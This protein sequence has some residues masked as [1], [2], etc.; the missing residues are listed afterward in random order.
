MR[1]LSPVWSQWGR[2]LHIAVF[3]L[4]DPDMVFLIQKGNVI[5]ANVCE[6]L[7]LLP[8][9]GDSPQTAR[10]QIHTVQILL[11]HGFSLEWATD[12]ILC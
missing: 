2:Q 12:P 1:S 6:S 3:L 11:F 8:T 4:L 10:F 7:L 5:S 9:H